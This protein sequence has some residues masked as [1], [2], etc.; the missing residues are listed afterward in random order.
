V[1]WPHL[2]LIKDLKVKPKE[3]KR[4]KKQ[5]ILVVKVFIAHS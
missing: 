4:G 3:L 1:V 5:E 2:W